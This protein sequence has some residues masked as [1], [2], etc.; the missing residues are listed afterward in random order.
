[1]KKRVLLIYPSEFYTSAAGAV[2]KVR[3]YLL[4]LKGFVREEAAVDI[5]DLET[6]YGRPADAAARDM[7]LARFRRE[8]AARPAYDVVGLSCYTTYSYWA[9]RYVADEVRSMLPS[10]TLVV[11]GYHPTAI[12][13][14]FAY[15]DSPFDFV[16]RGEGE[17]ALAEIVREELEP[18]GRPTI[19]NGRPLAP[20][21]WP[22]LELEQNGRGATIDLMPFAASRGCPMKCGFCCQSGEGANGWRAMGVGAALAA[23]ADL[24]DRHRFTMLKFTDAYFGK[25]SAWLGE[26]LGGLE[27]L[28]LPVIYW[29]EC[30]ANT[31][32][33]AVLERLRRMRFVMYLGVESLHAD[34]I[35]AMRKSYDPKRYIERCID[36]IQRCSQRDVPLEVGI[37]VNHPGETSATYHHTFRRFRDLA[38]DCQNVSFGLY[39]S[40][41]KVYPGN[42]TYDSLDDFEA[43][44]GTWVEDRN[45]WRHDYQDLR[46][47]SERTVASADLIAAYGH[48]PYYW[49]SEWNQVRVQVANRLTDRAF[50]V[51]RWQI[52]AHL[53]AVSNEGA[54]IAEDAIVDVL[55]E[56]ERLYNDAFLRIDDLWDDSAASLEEAREARQKA[57]VQKNIL[58]RFRSDTVKAFEKVL[59]RRGLAVAE[60]KRS[61]EEIVGRFQ[62]RIAA[63]HELRTSGV[64]E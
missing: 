43:D 33:D 28:D 16:V 37:L 23:I 5:L 56:I 18:T 8:L 49:L 35:G 61:S 54:G 25:S 46:R 44:C 57:I 9:C 60:F 45:W 53:C 36:A 20:E 34:V 50:R 48:N 3:T 52:T 1:M 51:K 38:D 41:F 6:L 58:L 7:F 55:R 15:A 19:V 13:E 42:H 26:F 47:L 14:D 27:R 12:P 39:T 63:W 30:R 17:I 40:G 32:T 2:E 10:A 64:Q 21:A 22:E 31:L 29:A 62:E 11:G 4:I 59:A 24:Y